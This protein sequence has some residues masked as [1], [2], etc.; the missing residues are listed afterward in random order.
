MISFAAGDRTLIGTVH[1]AVLR[2]SCPGTPVLTGLGAHEDGIFDYAREDELLYEHNMKIPIPFLLS[3]DGWGLL[4][5]AGYAMK[6]HGE[7]N[8]F[9][10]ELDA[11]EAVSYVVIH[12][13]DCADVLKKLAGI[14]GLPAM[15]PK[16]AFGYMQSKERYQ[17]ADELLSVARE[18]RRRG[19]GLDCIV[20]DWLTWQDG[21]WG[22]KTPDPSRFPDIRALTDALHQL[23]IHFM[24]SV[25]PNA[26]RGR[27]CDVLPGPVSSCPPAGSMTPFRPKPGHCTG[28]S[29]AVSG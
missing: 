26:D 14:I 12:G 9:S 22:D 17:S 1:S 21:C 20:Q 18:F 15:L 6:Y 28:S 29:A 3:S 25:W 7:G 13:K 2:F 16:W 24:V 5:E 27:D 8:A 23:N 11:V 19:L 10:F 4:I